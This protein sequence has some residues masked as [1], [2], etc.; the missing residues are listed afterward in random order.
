MIARAC[1]G[2]PWLFAQAAAALRG[3][4]IPPDPTLAEERAVDAA[5]LR[6]VCDR[7]GDDKGTVL[8]RKYACCYAQGR[9]GAREFRKHVARI[10]TPDEFSAVVEKY[11]PSDG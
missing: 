8:M 4:P 6:L 7:F 11:F 1:L 10:E 9:P 5:P 3:E 2:K